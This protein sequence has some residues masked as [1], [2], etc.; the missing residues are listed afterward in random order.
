METAGALS[1]R[2][3]SGCSTILAGGE[4]RQSAVAISLLCWERQ[5]TAAVTAE[6]GAATTCHGQRAAG[7][8]NTS[9]ELEQLLVGTALHVDC[10]SGSSG[11]RRKA[12]S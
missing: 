3:Q 6:S 1:D 7:S 8:M 10:S 11:P 2:R 9:W 4:S 5:P 12:S